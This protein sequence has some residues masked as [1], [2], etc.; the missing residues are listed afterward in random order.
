MDEPRSPRYG[1]LRYGEVYRQSYPKRYGRHPTYSK[2]G[3]HRQVTYGPSEDP[4]HWPHVADIMFSMINW[5]CYGKTPYPD[6]LYCRTHCCLVKNAYLTSGGS[7]VT[8][9]FLSNSL[10][11]VDF[12]SGNTVD[13]QF[14]SQLFELYDHGLVLACGVD[15]DIS[16][17]GQSSKPYDSQFYVGM[18]GDHDGAGTLDSASISQISL[19]PLAKVVEYN[20]ID[21]SVRLDAYAENWTLTGE[22]K[23]YFEHNAALRCNGAS[24]L[25]KLYW[26]VFVEGMRS[27][28]HPDFD[29]EFTLA[30]TVSHYVH[31]WGRIAQYSQPT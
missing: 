20:G 31:M 21:S 1:R 7:R 2:W 28:V 25:I 9:H 15:V 29:C 16:C 26:H 3:Q 30:I 23:S 8:W 27:I 22:S 19:A 6:D 11:N 17:T 14:C 10:F 5:S 18:Y 24:P 12:L 13:D 4:R